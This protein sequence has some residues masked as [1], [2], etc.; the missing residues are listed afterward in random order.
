MRARLKRRLL[1]DDEFAR[2]LAE[3]R[4]L[5]DP[6]AHLRTPEDFP[7]EYRPGPDHCLSP[8]YGPLRFLPTENPTG[9][10]EEDDDPHARWDQ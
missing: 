6:Y 4:A 9:H 10:N 3:H 2:L 8:S 1:T 7:G 5:P